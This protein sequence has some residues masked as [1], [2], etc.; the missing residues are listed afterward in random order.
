LNTKDG[1]ADGGLRPLTFLLTGGRAPVALEL[2]RMLA[3]AGAGHRVYVAESL[4]RHLCRVSRAVA[5]S[6]VVPSP[7]EDF[8]AYVEALVG[9]VRKYGVDM[10]IPTCEEVMHVAQGAE[11]LSEYCTLF[12]DSFAKLKRLH[13]KWAFIRRAEELGFQVPATKLITSSAEW[14][15]AA[16]H[17]SVRDGLVLKPVFSRFA[18]KVVVIEPQK[19]GKRPW[20]GAAPEVT[21]ANSWIAQQYIS[22]RQL[23]TYAIVHGGTAVAHAAYEARYTAGRGACVQFQ[24]LEHPAA[25]DWVNRFVKL[26]R[27]TG[28]IAFDFIETADGTLYPLECNPRATSGLHLLRDTPG[29]DMAFAAPDKL[30]GKVLVAAEEAKAMIAPAMLMYGMRD[31]RSWNGWKGWAQSFV[32]SRDVVFRREDWRPAIEQVR[33]LRLLRGIGRR[34]KITLMEASTYDIEWNGEQR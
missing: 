33:L 24:P 27:F 9:I 31:I 30:G 5:G 16:E 6:F 12:A 23:C 3:G 26:E 17:A 22:G 18:A 8:A 4:P 32:T 25:V 15:A 13:S 19:A 29:M 11:S 28:Q 34:K 21:A 7:R 10:L 20:R 14:L 2:A 1:D